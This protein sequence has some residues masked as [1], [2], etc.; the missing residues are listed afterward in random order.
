MP[1]PVTCRTRARSRRR[2]TQTSSN[3]AERT[4]ACGARVRRVSPRQRAST[5][6]PVAGRRRNTTPSRIPNSVRPVHTSRAQRRA[7]TSGN[8]TRTR[9][10]AARVRVR[11]LRSKH[12]T[13]RQSSAAWRQTP[14]PRLLARFCAPLN[15]T[16]PP[17]TVLA[18]SRVSPL[19]GMP[20]D[21]PPNSRQTTR[22]DA[23]ASDR[24]LWG[25]RSDLAGPTP[26][27]S[28]LRR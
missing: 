14:R 25:R 28:T 21:R 7:R 24:A 12:V 27:R 2:A 5:W 15:S 23:R 6:P 17:S 18:R 11:R 9:S 13:W 26:D 4:L 19:T 20:L 10:V 16:R 8:A 3:D 1:W 22:Y